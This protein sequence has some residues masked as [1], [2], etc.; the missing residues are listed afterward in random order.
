MQTRRYFIKLR[1]M[2][3]E[4]TVKKLTL[5]I[6]YLTLELEQVKETLHVCN[7]G[8]MQYLYHLQNEHDIKI[9]KD[10]PNKSPKPKDK[11]L[12]EDIRV[13][14]KH[15]KKQDKIFKMINPTS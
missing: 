15:D 8:W 2:K 9:F 10:S 3:N 4:K 11:C 14:K 6:R 13:N 12:N 1:T 7:A 5:K